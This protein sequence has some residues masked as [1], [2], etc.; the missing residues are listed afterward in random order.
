M[1]LLIPIVIEQTA[2]GERSYD[3]YSRLLKDRIMFLSGPI[4]DHVAN[5]IIAQLLFLES[6]DQT[7]EISLYINSPGGQV[8]SALA[9]YDTMMHIKP[10]IATYCIGLAA[11][12]GSLLLTAGTKG[13]RFALPNSKII[14]HQP[15]GGCSGQ[16]SDILIQANE[17]KKTRDRLNKIYTVATNKSIEEIEKVMDRDTYMTAQEA[18]DF[19]LIDTVLQSSKIDAALQSSKIDNMQT[20][21][22]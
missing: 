21:N 3:I 17:I 4:N 7:K 5:L 2:K 14:V 22:S 12:A 13:K 11:S 15:L 19:G 10:D 1:S 18:K 16:A 20:I 9:M 6:Q 8:T